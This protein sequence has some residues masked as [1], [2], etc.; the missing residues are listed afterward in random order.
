MSFI[1]LS[2]T[3]P[4]IEQVNKGNEYQKQLAIRDA[5]PDLKSLIT[6]ASSKNKIEVKVSNVFVFAVGDT[7]AI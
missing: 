6:A 1:T 7:G 3:S 5:S 4:V 2:V